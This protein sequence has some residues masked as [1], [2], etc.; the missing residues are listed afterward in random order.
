[1]HPS[2]I[3]QTCELSVMN[4]SS[5]NVSRAAITNG[6][7]IFTDTTDMLMHLYWRKIF[8]DSIYRVDESVFRL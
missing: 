7:Y 8:V 6:Q 2:S 3:R 5:V 4:S 1:L